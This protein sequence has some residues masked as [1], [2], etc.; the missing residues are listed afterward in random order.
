MANRT[1]TMTDPLYD[2]FS[3]VSLRESDLQ[4]RLREETAQL[5]ESGMQVAPEQGQF[6][7]LLAQVVRAKR[8]LEVGVFTGYSSLAI[9]QVLPE[10][11]QIIACDVNRQW[12]DIARRYWREAGVD[13]KIDLRL[14]PAVQ[15]LDQLIADGHAGSFDFA[16][17]DADKSNYDA[18]YERA[19][20]LVRP[21]ALIAID[22]VLWH[23]KPI[24]PTMQDPDTQAIRAFNMK[25]QQDQRI[26]LS[27]VPIGDGITLAFKR[28]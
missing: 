11:G 9:A 12:T 14:A 22:N 17:I 23:G 6:L 19:L 15:T 24:D 7:A 26:S 25:L 16:F 18:Y 28:P 4:R 8:T 21:A 1:I 13:Q 20:A 5:P 3:S 10:D 2:Y 27:L